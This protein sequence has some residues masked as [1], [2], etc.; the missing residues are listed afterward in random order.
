[1]LQDHFDFARQFAGFAAI[2]AADIPS[3]LTAVAGSA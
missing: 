1:L 3:I 2:P